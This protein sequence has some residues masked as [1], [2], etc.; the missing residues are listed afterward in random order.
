[1][2]SKLVRSQLEGN[3]NDDLNVTIVDS[4][5]DSAM[6]DANDAVNVNV[7]AGS[8]SGTEFNEDDAASGGEA[9]PQ[10]L[11]VRRDADTT[12]VST[13]G[14]FHTLI[15]DAA[16][17]LKV[18]VKL[19]SA[20]GTEFNEDSAHT[21]G[22]AGPQ[23]LGVR[24]DADTTPVSADG[25]YHHLV[26]D[27]TGNLKVNVKVGSASGTEFNEDTAHTTGAAGPQ[28]LGV[29]RDADTSPVSTDGDYHHLVFNDSGALK[30]EV[31]DGGDSHTV[32]G[33]V[34]VTHPALGGGVEA[35][36]QRVTIANDST[37]LVSVDDGGGALTVDNGG[38]F[39]VQEDGA[40]L[41]ALQLIDNPVA[42]LGTAT[43]TE[44]TTSG[45]IVGAVRNDILAALANTDNEIAPLQVNAT[46]A[47]YVEVDSSALPSGAATS[48][49]QLA[50]GHN[51][52]VDNA[53]GGS[54]VNVQDGGN[55]LTV[56]N[57]GTFVVQEDGAALTALQIIDNPV[58]VDDAAFTLASSS[59]EM[60]G[61][62]RD[63]VLS[64]LTAVEGDAVPLR[65]N[66]T[67][68]LHITGAAAG[69][70]F[71]E[72]TA[73]TTG[74]AGPQIL[75]V[76]RD[77][78]TSPVTTDGDY[79]HLVFNDSGALKVE[80][81]DGGDSF[82]VDNAGTFVVQEDGAALT[83]LQLIDNPVFVDDAAFTLTSSSVEMAG[84][85]RDDT[86]S[87][88]A[89][90]AGD[91]VPLRVD[92]DGALQVN[93]GAETA[94]G[95]LGALN[96][97]V[98]ITC[99]RGPMVSFEIRNTGSLASST[100][101]FEASVDGTNWFAVA[102]MGVD[103]RL[104]ETI[105]DSSLPSRGFFI[106][107]GWLQVRIRVSVFGSGSAT[108]TLVA[109]NGSASTIAVVGNVGHDGSN[110]GPPILIGHTSAEFNADP[111]TVSADDDRTDSLCNPQGMQYVLEGHPN[112]IHREYMT[113]AVQTDDP[114]ID[115]VAAGSQI[116][117]YAI[118]ALVSNATTPSP[119]IRIGFGAANVP[120]E[121]ASGATVDGIVLSHGG[122]APGSGVLRKGVKVGGDGEEL[123]IT[124]AVPT[125]GKIT[126]LVD[127]YIST[128]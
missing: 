84:A 105:N 125:A 103:V 28:I 2:G 68:A 50:D 115:S 48:A 95:S 40:A 26:F 62:T 76:R 67:G 24:R 118:E 101:A 111:P 77:A 72:D 41:T 25:D 114:I 92:V 33:T 35:G 45:S 21:T 123:R 5:G 113:T 126:V 112:M 124:N 30:V 87:A 52:T 70:E 56:D 74:A 38:T 9:G 99:K 122:V 1:M 66:S 55:S 23:I 15:F 116:V 34:T 19:G 4:T 88:L 127:F 46:G 27:D 60:A 42:V 90:A 3:A 102:A 69:T 89:A 71:N 59:V 79:H 107:N 119:Q 110:V 18:N 47:L 61:A 13:D 37:G 14:D 11:G 120:T 117:I 64:T 108:A 75:G 10:I 73:H 31:F 97:A 80:A 81:F 32:D 91:A 98:T 63:D 104:G 17:N 100:L 109:S 82:T 6:D 39:V 43:Y 83:A 7:V 106:E 78:D 16:G 85:I 93:A 94:T 86:L 49:N 44:A 8:A 22:D 53:S 57:G 29:R 20:S 65:V 96:A 51:V 128:L 54:A 121:P 36:A 58:F 12:P